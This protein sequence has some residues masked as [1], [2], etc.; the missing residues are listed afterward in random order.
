MASK[1]IWALD[2]SMSRTGVAIFDESGELV[3]V[4]SIETK[5]K[6]KAQVRLE[7]IAR[8]LVYLDIDHP[9]EILVMERGFSRFNLAT[10]ALFRVHGVVNYLFWTK[11]QIY[12]PPKVIKQSLVGGKAT[13]QEIYDWVRRRFPETVP[14]NDDESDAIAIG[15]CYFNKRKEDVEH[16]RTADISG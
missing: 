9:C 15:C 1:Y 4:T 16:E 12:Y 7:H 3:K 6:D 10:Q 11:E 13:K 5:S 14:A 2:I 8:N